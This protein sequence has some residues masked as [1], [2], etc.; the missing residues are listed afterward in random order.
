[1]EPMAVSQAQL[2]MTEMQPEQKSASYHVRPFPGPQDGTPSIPGLEKFRSYHLDHVLEVLN[3][4]QQ[5]V[6]R[7]EL[8]P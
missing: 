5:L 2:K 6:S 8:S 7:P 4:K 3:L 1:M